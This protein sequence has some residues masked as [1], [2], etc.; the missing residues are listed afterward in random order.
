MLIGVPKEIKVHE[1]R[2][3]MTPS[4]VRELIVQGY[5]CPLKTKASK[6]KIDTS[7]LHVRGGEFIGHDH[8]FDACYVCRADSGPAAKAEVLAVASAMRAEGFIPLATEWWHFDAPGWRAFP[9]MDS[10]PYDRPLFPDAAA[11]GAGP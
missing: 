5:L 1:Y 7:N 4:A 8:D 10:N 3:G 9:V 6:R 2:V 11:A